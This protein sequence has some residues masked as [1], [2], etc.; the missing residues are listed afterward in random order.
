MPN[1]LS[2][3]GRQ[4][5]SNA[6]PMPHICMIYTYDAHQHHMPAHQCRQSAKRRLTILDMGCGVGGSSR[7]ML[8][9]LTAA[10]Y[11]VHVT[12]ITLSSYQQGRATALSAGLCTG[13]AAGSSIQFKV[14]CGE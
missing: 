6:I 1:T 3:H 12:G 2:L 8:R 14:L 13:A 11:E 5:M 4:M 9:T 7:F 10:G